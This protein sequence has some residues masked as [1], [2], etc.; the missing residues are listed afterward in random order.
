MKTILQLGFSLIISC[1]ALVAADSKKA[2]AATPS[3]NLSEFKLGELITGPQASLA[4]ASGKAVLIEAWGVHCGPCIA[5][6]PHIES[7]AKR[8]KGKLLVFGA[9]SQNA[10]DEEVKQVVKKNNLS[11][12]IT[13]GVNG[14]VSFRGIPHAFVFDTTGALIFSGH[15]MDRAFDTAVQKA[16]R[17]ASGSTTGSSTGLDALKALQAK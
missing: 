16:T 8:N 3:H 9:H 11:Y 1:S 7:L 5:S 15:P 6:L 13:K 10:S 4:D 2:A 12:S 14:P 17:G